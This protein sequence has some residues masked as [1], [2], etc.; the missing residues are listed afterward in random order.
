MRGIGEV[1][2]ASGLSVS[3]LRFY[4]GAGVL[5]PAEVDAATGYRRYADEQVRAARLIAGLRRVGMPVSEIAR[6]VRGLGDPGTV[7]RQLDQ[8]RRRLEDGLAD[9]RRELLRIHTLLDLE[10][11][12]M[13]RI[14]LPAA[15][16]AAA[17]GAVRFAAGNDPEIPQLGGVLA[18]TGA[19]TL[20]LVATDRY[21]LAVAST[22][23]A[24]EGPPARLLLPLDFVDKLGSALRRGEAVLD[25][26]AGRVRAEV[27]GEAVEGVP[28]EADFPD[29]RRLAG[30]AQPGVRRVTVDVAALRERVAAAPATTREHEG[31][32]YEISVLAVDAAGGLRLAAEGEW[33]AQAEAHV[34]VNREF[35][36]QALDAGGAGQLVLELDGP[37][38]PLAVRVPGDDSRFSI[39]MPVR[40]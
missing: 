13:T 10:E 37:I 20:T 2:R 34:A 35:L 30:D 32:P 1:A 38:K 4:D 15:A 5:V 16:L 39:L 26:A 19:E 22:P 29:H 23:A 18:E 6:A 11:N 36:L 24:V 21:R 9:A 8:H 12:L 31:S 25:L 14:T 33:A 27:A 7:R 28:V 40:H 17:I 3:A